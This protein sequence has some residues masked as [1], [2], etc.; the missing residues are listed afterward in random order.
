MIASPSPEAAI[1]LRTTVKA[2]PPEICTTS[3]SP[4]TSTGVERPV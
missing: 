3:V 1:T 2:P 4:I